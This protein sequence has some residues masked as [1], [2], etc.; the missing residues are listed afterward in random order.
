MTSEALPPGDAV[1]RPGRVCPFAKIPH[2]VL[3]ADIPDKSKTLYTLLNAHVNNHA[4]NCDVVLRQDKLAKMLGLKKAEQVKRYTDP[5]VALGAVEVRHERHGARNMKLRIVYTVHELPPDGYDGMRS[6]REFHAQEKA[7][8]EKTAGHTAPPN[9][10]VPAPPNLGVPAP[11]NLGDELELKPE[12]EEERETPAPPAPPRF[13]APRPE[14]PEIINAEIIRM[15]ADR[16]G[17]TI[18]AEHADRVRR[19]ILSRATQAVGSPLLYVVA[20]LRRTPDCGVFLPVELLE[21]YQART[22]RP[23]RGHPDVPAAPTPARPRPVELPQDWR[24]TEAMRRW[25]HRTYPAVDV[26][27]ATE[28]FIAHQRRHAGRAVD[29]V[30]AWQKWIITAHEFAAKDARQGAAA[31]GA[32]RGGGRKSGAEQRHEQATQVINRMALLDQADAAEAAGDHVTAAALRA[33]Y[34]ALRHDP[35]P[36]AG[37]AVVQGHVVTTPELE[38]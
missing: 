22:G 11:P 38:A 18:T 37:P 27:L 3:L 2:W 13:G 9:L 14:D 25:A 15:I 32:P 24:P 34:E 16:T 30:A 35:A 26:N 5:L 20:T 7:K 17:Y 19:D 6:L 21:A 23:V 8:E 33:Q 29:W 4:D 10:G 12:L 28:K 36:S 31:G 1:A